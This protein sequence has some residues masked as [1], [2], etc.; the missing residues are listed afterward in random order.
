MEKKMKIIP[1]DEMTKEQKR[2]YDFVDAHYKNNLCT[3]IEAV[4]FL[5][6]YKIITEE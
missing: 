4:E 1:Y 5:K 6:T 2:A 3:L